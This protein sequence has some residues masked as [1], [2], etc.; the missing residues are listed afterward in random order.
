[1]SPRKIGPV[2]SNGLRV[3]QT[4]ENNNIADEYQEQRVPSTSM[5]KMRLSKY[6]GIVKNAVAM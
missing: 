1:M 2:S 5:L 3:A 4:A 6:E